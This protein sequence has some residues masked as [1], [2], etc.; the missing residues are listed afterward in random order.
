MQT[1]GPG[2]LPAGPLQDV[3]LSSEPV[4]WHPRPYD[5]VLQPSN[6]DFAPGKHKFRSGWPSS[7]V[8]TLHMEA[9]HTYRVLER[10]EGATAGGVYTALLRISDDDRSGGHEVLEVPCE[11]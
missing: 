4:V 6:L 7:C 1:V 2:P 10:R 3:I 11:R 8:F 5:H 9:G